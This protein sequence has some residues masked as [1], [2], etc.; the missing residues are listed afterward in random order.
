MNRMQGEMADELLKHPNCRAGEP[1][2][3]MTASVVTPIS[4]QVFCSVCGECL[5]PMIRRCPW[6]SYS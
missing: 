5:G 6:C 2:K 3:E 1:E 4:S